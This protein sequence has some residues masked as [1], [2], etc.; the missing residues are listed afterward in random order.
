MPENG[1]VPLD[2]PMEFFPHAAGPST[3]S[4]TPEDYHRIIGVSH[5]MDNPN[6]HDRTEAWSL[7]AEEFS[8]FPPDSSRFLSGPGVIP[9]QGVVSLQ[10][11]AHSPDTLGSRHDEVASFDDQRSAI[12]DQSSPGD[13]GELRLYENS[14]SCADICHDRPRKPK[15]WGGN[16]WRATRCTGTYRASRASKIDASPRERSANPPSDTCRGEIET[17]T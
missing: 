4:G 2:Q 3:V 15:I 14:K 17:Q 13:L 10:V 5:D 11:P 1:A 9:G 6:I 7:K 12:P 16:M 8:A